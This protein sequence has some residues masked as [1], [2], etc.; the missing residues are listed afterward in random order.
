MAT[1][2]QKLQQ[3]RTLKKM[4]VEEVAKATKI[5]EQFIIA[6]EADDYQAFNEEFYIKQYIRTYAYFLGL[7]ARTLIADIDEGDYEEKGEIHV[8]QLLFEQK[9]RATERTQRQFKTMDV[10]QKFFLVFLAFIIL[11]TVW[12][13]SVNFMPK[14]EFQRQGELGTITTMR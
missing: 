13:M 14:R 12:F 11:V 10:L 5:N 3:A 9:R 4:T 1:I 8:S 6:V 7:N 2:G